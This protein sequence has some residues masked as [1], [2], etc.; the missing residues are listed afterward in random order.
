MGRRKRE[1]KGKKPAVGRARERR[2]KNFNL[3]K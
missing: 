1:E 2:D 3:K